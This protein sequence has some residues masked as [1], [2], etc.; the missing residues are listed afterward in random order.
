MFKLISLETIRKGN[1]DAALEK[2]GYVRT[3]Q[4]ALRWGLTPDRVNKYF[5]AGYTCD[6]FKINGVRYISVDAQ[7]PKDW[8]AERK[9]K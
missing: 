4:M 8:I 3:T 9:K 7:N 1:L 6:C 5:S 2:F